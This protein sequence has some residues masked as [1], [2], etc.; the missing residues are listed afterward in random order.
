MKKHPFGSV[1]TTHTPTL[2]AARF[3]F[4]ALVVASLLSPLGPAAV[5]APRKGPS[6]IDPPPA[7]RDMAA[8]AIVGVTII[9]GTGRAPV[10]DGVVLIRG[11]R[12]AA[13]GTRDAVRIPRGAR[14]TSAPGM[15]LIPGMLDAHFHLDGDPGL[16]N[17]FLRHGV[18][19]VRD[20]GQWIEAYAPLK[21]RG[22]ALPR[23]FLMG[24]HLDGL[25]PAY[26]EDSHVVRDAE[27]TRLAVK[28]FAAQGASGIKVYFRLPLGL[29]REA[30][31]TAHSLG[32]PVT[33]HLEIVDARDAVAA[34]I[35]GIEHVT[36]LGTALIPA[37]EAEVY[38]QAVLADNAARRVGRYRVWIGVDPNSERSRELAGYLAR[39]GTFLSPTLAIFERRE[40]DR[41]ATP[42]NVR[43]FRTMV[44][45]V[46]MARRAG[47]RVVVGS[48]SSVPK[49]ERGWAYQR[50]MELLL[51]A[52]MSP[53]EIISAATLENARF[54]RVSHRLGSVEVGKEADLVLVRG[55]PL[56]DFG[57]MRR[58]ERVMLN[59][60]WVSESPNSSQQQ[61]PSWV[62]RSQPAAR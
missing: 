55:N 29:I 24:P 5:S 39:R 58:V 41:Q 59:G 60:S 52:G 9:D 43:A 49:A 18:T 8:Q 48:H 45:F 17:L 51:E 13:A 36:S 34:G 1:T 37:R 33:A 21:A 46:G 53:L 42:E 26:P 54:F 25:S 32:L 57:A 19:S 15:T 28:R 56:E 11:A 30:V 31:A 23:L 44:A 16:P 38:R 6:E 3:L 61:D 7:P 27:E 40:G 2:L 20:P 35:D 10:S 14:V 12:I 62:V 47:V 50:E 22:E 4:P